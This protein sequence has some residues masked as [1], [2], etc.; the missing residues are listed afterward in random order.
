MSWNHWFLSRLRIFIMFWY[1]GVT[2]L[3]IETLTIK[4]RRCSLSCYKWIRFL[5]SLQESKSERPPARTI[6]KVS[7]C[8]STNSFKWWLMPYCGISLKF[9][10]CW[11]FFMKT[12]SNCCSTVFYWNSSFVGGNHWS[13]FKWIE[14]LLSWSWLCHLIRVNI[15][16]LLCLWISF[17]NSF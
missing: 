4:H 2:N 8:F 16:F 14:S 5:I 15:H 7:F 9:P 12:S 10:H 3:I 11:G 6:V 13:M 17:F 1:F